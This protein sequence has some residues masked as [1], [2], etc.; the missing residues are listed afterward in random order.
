MTSTNKICPFGWSYPMLCTDNHSSAFLQK[1]K[2][3]CCTLCEGQCCSEHKRLLWAKHYFAR[4]FIFIATNHMYSC[5]VNKTPFIITIVFSSIFGCTEHWEASPLENSC[6]GIYANNRKNFNKTSKKKRKKRKRLRVTPVMIN[7]SV[8]A[9]F[10]PCLLLFFLSSF[11]FC[12]RYGISLQPI[13]ITKA[14]NK[15]YYNKTCCVWYSNE[16]INCQCPQN[17]DI[18]N[19]SWTSLQ[20]EAKC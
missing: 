3:L 7:N 1:I 12:S 5:C 15:N 18:Q 10:F 8:G 2:C 17:C 19:L 4:E 6:F 20:N 14:I 11:C 9:W 16:L 13:M